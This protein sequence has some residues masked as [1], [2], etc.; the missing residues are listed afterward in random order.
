VRVPGY[1]QRTGKRLFVQPSF[2]QHGAG[3]MFQTSTRANGVYFHY[4]WSEEDRVEIT[5][6]EGYALDSPESPVPLSAG[7]LSRYEP[8]AGVSK[9]GRTLVYTRRFSFGQGGDQ[10]LRFP[11]GSYAGLKGYF[12]QLS[13]QDAHTIALKQQ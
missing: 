8:A 3:A 2:F 1:A 4:P 5:L 7:E 9:D 13:R 12:D 10:M 11:V 6:P